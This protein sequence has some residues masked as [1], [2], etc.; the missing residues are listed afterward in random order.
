[1][2]APQGCHL[3]LVNIDQ[4]FIH[5][6]LPFVVV[7]CMHIDLWSKDSLYRPIFS[8]SKKCIACFQSS[9][10]SCK[11]ADG[12]LHLRTKFSQDLG[13]TPVSLGP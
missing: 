7:S 6:F 3:L 12:E 1:M 10:E 8:K 9:A 4:Y 5:V 2:V 13:Y 11:E